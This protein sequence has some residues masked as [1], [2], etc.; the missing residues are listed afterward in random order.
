VSLNV[1]ANGFYKDGK[2]VALPAKITDKGFS[3]G[4]V[5]KRARGGS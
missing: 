2:W 5:G 1:S 3:A 4:G